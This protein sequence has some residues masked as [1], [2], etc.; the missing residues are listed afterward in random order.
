MSDARAITRLAYDSSDPYFLDDP[1]PYYGWLREEQPVH[2]HEASGAYL[3]S[4]FADVWNAAADWPTFS[5][6]SPVAAH[7]HFASM[8]PPEHDRLRGAVAPH[9]APGRIAR[10]EPEVRA[11]CRALLAPLEG[12]AS[13]DLVGEFAA[14]FPSRVVQR[15]VGVPDALGE[16]MRHRALGIASAPDSARLV[17]ILEEL[18][19]LSRQAVEG[20]QA[21]ERP[22]LI[23]QLAAQAGAAAL[24]REQRVGICSN[25][26]L[27]GTDTVA[28]LIG[29]GVVLLH[30]H[31]EQRELL[32]RDPARLP[33]AIEEM[34]R[35][36][37]PA[38]SL[39]RRTSR[40][41]RLHGVEIVAGAEVRLMWG[42]ANRDPREFERAEVFDVQRPLRRHLAFGHGIHFCVGAA[43]ARLEA[44]VAFEEILA[45]WPRYRVVESALV[46]L[47]SFWVRG[48]ERVPVVPG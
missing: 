8:D 15:V 24:S 1:Y 38:Q 45:R 28:N 31:P 34:L 47:P 21:P 13:F 43:L 33:G 39:G 3:L 14:R 23:Q 37:S 30:R 25:L 29:N 10:L 46:R 32:A 26:V 41:V 2:R 4:R 20:S 35:F 22:G 36:E 7:K 48:Y 6:Q 16:A 27:A 40:A 5:S 11:V 18:E 44:R 42:A 19:A 9:L 17:E 12:A